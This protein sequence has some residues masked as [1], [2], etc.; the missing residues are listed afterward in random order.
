MSAPKRDFHS[1]VGRL[2]ELESVKERIQEAT[3]VATLKSA[4][5]DLC[6]II[7]PEIDAYGSLA[8]RY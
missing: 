2:K 5:L 8:D 7:R 3:D 1:V 4:M 6:E